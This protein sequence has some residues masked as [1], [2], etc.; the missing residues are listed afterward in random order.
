MAS[1]KLKENILPRGALTFVSRSM[2]K[3]KKINKNAFRIGSVVGD[4]NI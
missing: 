2:S 1:F 4:D 3:D